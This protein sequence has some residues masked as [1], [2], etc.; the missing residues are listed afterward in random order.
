MSKHDDGTG[1]GVSRS[2][3]RYHGFMGLM[4]GVLSAHWYGRMRRWLLPQ[5]SDVRCTSE[6]PSG[7]LGCSPPMWAV[8]SVR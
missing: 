4:Y 1:W 2:K 8:G 7:D 3:N 6:L 5:A